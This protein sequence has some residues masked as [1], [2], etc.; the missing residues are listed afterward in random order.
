MAWQANLNYDVKKYHT[1]KATKMS[2]VCCSTKCNFRINTTEEGNGPGVFF[3]KVQ[4][5]H[6]CPGTQKRT[7][8]YPAN[9]IALINTSAVNQFHAQDNSHDTSALCKTVNGASG[10][11]HIRTTVARKLLEGLCGRNKLDQFTQFA[12]L[13]AYVKALTEN[14][15]NGTFEVHSSK[16]PGDNRF[17]YFYV[18]PGVAKSMWLDLRDN[19]TVDGC[20]VFTIVRGAL[21]VCASLTSANDIIILALYYCDAENGD[22]CARFIKL[23][24]RDFPARVGSKVLIFQDAGRGLIQGCDVNEV[25]WRRCCHHLVDALN[26]AEGTVPTELEKLIYIL[27]RCTTQEVTDKTIAKMRKD[28]PSHEAA[29]DWTVNSMHNFV[30]SFFIEHGFRSFGQITNNPAEEVNFM[31]LPYRRMA[32]IDMFMSILKAFAI[33]YEK[34]KESAMKR[35]K[36]RVRGTTSQFDL[37]QSAFKVIER[38]MKSVEGK[39]VIIT[40]HTPNKLHG[41]VVLDR[42]NRIEAVVQLSLT[43]GSES[44]ICSHCR[45]H[46]DTGLLCSCAIA[47]VVASNNKQRRNSN[48]FSCYDPRLAHEQLRTATWVSQFRHEFTLV[49]FCIPPC[50]SED[51][52]TMLKPWPTQPSKPGRKKKDLKNT[53]RHRYVCTGCGKTGHNLRRCLRVNLDSVREKL[54]T[55]KTS[56]MAQ[57]SK[58]SNGNTFYTLTRP[59]VL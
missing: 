20:A 43:P 45:V 35:M 6:N 13:P 19:L 30:S 49:P 48:A 17:E 54:E 21:L 25:L 33:K 38:R 29:I 50:V 53:T 22:H 16:V 18:A 26:K 42:K 1:G 12:H 9:I 56:N 44:C 39:Q 5:V 10:G 23:C 41:T 8:G 7:R 2:I 47:L 40:A 14:D 51:S 36:L 58:K 28:F 52:M 15:V 4:P 11:I 59:D 34:D 32:V 27:A 3:S 37:V 31:I 55:G 57:K 46:F 24:L